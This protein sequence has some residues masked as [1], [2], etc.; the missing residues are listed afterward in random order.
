MKKIL[1][2]LVA[3]C[4]VVGLQAASKK[5]E[6]Q[7]TTG[8]FLYELEFIESAAQ[9]MVMVKVW[10]Q[11]KKAELAMDLSAINAVHGVI[12]KGYASQGSRMSH[13][14]LVQ[15]PVI[16]S[17]KKDFFDQFFADKSNY[18]RYVVNIVDGSM[19]VKKVG[20]EYKVAQIVTVNKDML[21]KHLEQ[22]GVIRGL[23]SGF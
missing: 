10:S 20:K 3:L 5:K 9:G 19:E 23:S 16:A 11:A 17:T 21:R 6:A 14:P 12:F 22:A 15:D 1:A 18:M 8:Q 13:R 4:M 7:A 2:V